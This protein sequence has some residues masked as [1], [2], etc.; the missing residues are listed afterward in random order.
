MLLLAARKQSQA[1]SAAAPSS[2]DEILGTDEDELVERADASAHVDISTYGGAP[3]SRS[4]DTVRLAQI[5]WTGPIDHD[6]IQVAL[7][8][9]PVED[10]SAAILGVEASGEPLPGSAVLEVTIGQGDLALWPVIL[11]KSGSDA[12]P[13]LQAL[14]LPER[15][16]GVTSPT[17]AAVNP[18]LAAYRRCALEHAWHKILGLPQNAQ[19]RR[20]LDETA[21]ALL[22]TLRALLGER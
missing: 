21:V 16:A 13:L 10:R 19:V 22:S 4:I 8:C 20:E 18:V 14:R 3:L 11:R 12:M 2:A 1:G 17:L 9:F 7:E 6:G 15:I 5:S